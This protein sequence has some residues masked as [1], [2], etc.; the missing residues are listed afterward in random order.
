[1]DYHTAPGVEGLTTPG[2]A[3]PWRLPRE[4]PLPPDQAARDRIVEDLEVSL[5]V[6]AG[7]G[8][9]KT[10]AL[11]ERMV[12]LLATGKAEA[13]EIAAVTFTK[14]AAA[15]LRERFQ[16]ALEEGFHRS[17]GQ[18]DDIVAE[19][20]EQALREIERG[21]IGTIHA[22]CARLLRERPIAA[23]LDPAFR[24]L[25][26]PEAEEHRRRFWHKWV[27]QRGAAEDEALPE[28]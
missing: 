4:G 10:T 2:S 13:A 3:A 6:E 17:R 24:E 20:L 16:I 26:G 23:G 18:G 1:M 11:L 22:F 14:K 21:F 27:E 9:G 19:R 5:L 28:L 8:S 15:E 7:A 25:V 12:A